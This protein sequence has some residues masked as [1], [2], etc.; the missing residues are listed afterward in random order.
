MVPEGGRGAAEAAKQPPPSIRTRDGTRCTGDGLL[1]HVR[2][3]EGQFAATTTV[4]GGG[5][6]QL[7]NLH[8]DVAV[9]LPLDPSRAAD[10][11]HYDEYGVPLTGTS[12]ATYGWL[13]GYQRAAAPPGGSVVMGMRVYTPTTGRFLQPD[14]VA[15][16]APSRYAYPSDPVNGSDLDGQRWKKKTWLVKK[17]KAKKLAT[18]L[19]AGARLLSAFGRIGI[20]IPSWASRIIGLVLEA[21]GGGV[22]WLATEIQLKAAMPKSKG[23]KITVGWWQ[24]YG[25]WWNKWIIYPRVQVKR[26]KK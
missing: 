7:T 17:K 22:R 25:S 20:T 3:A 11:R 13:G 16:G 23:V 9:S 5:V 14:P 21:V 18:S 6:L 4:D 1:R 19:K 26:W 15:E 24:K 10:V 2:D 8:G 12:A